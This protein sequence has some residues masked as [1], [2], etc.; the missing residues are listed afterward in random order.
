MQVSGADKSL[1]LTEEN[2]AEKEN[3][4]NYR[5]RLS[6]STIIFLSNKNYS[7][8]KDSQ[9]ISPQLLN[10]G[11]SGL[12][13]IFNC[14]RTLRQQPQPWEQAAADVLFQEIF[15]KVSFSSLFYSLWLIF[16]Q[17]KAPTK[18]KH[19]SM[20]H[21]WTYLYICELNVS[22]AA[23]HKC[24]EKFTVGY[25]EEMC[26]WYQCKEISERDNRDEI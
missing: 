15:Q 19:P 21:Q 25:P 5:C 17:K 3:T 12:K 9:L 1:W 10:S 8:T 6:K 20:K 2:I 24:E 16:E 4:A 26:E 23:G 18:Q 7:I 14:L 22:F 11:D 13:N